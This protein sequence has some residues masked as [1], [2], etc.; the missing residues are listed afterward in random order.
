MTAA[1]ETIF[2]LLRDAHTERTTFP[3]TLLYNEGWLLRLVLSV[4]SRLGG[5]APLELV[6]GARWYSEAR[7]YSPFAAVRRGDRV[8]ETHTHADAVIGHVGIAPGTKT[9][10]TLHEMA[11]QFVAIE[12]KIF[13]GLAKRTTN[14]PDYDQAARYVACMAHT[15]TRAKVPLDRL[16]SLAFLVIVPESQLTDALRATLDKSALRARVAARAARMSE[17]RPGL[18]GWVGQH[19]EP[20]LERLSLVPVSWEEIIERIAAADATLGGHVR[21]FYVRTLD[22]N[23]GPRVNPFNTLPAS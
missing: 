12:A 6:P 15:I 4:T 23:G 14:A 10:L 1:L 22:L 17:H 7:L 3:P 2:D 8:G 18:R 5:C 16:S 13:S 9:G 21:E 19:V 11:T 20:M